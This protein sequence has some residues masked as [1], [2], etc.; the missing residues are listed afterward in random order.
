MKRGFLYLLIS[1]FTFFFANGQRDSK[2][3]HWGVNCSGELNY[4]G[5]YVAPSFTLDKNHSIS[6]GPLFNALPYYIMFPK[7]ENKYYP[8]NHQFYGGRIAYDHF[9]YTKRRYANIF[10]S[11]NLTFHHTV[12]SEYENSTTK[13]IISS[14]NKVEFL[15]LYLGLGNNFY[16]SPNFYFNYGINWGITIYENFDR[17]NNLAIP[18]RG[19]L[20]NTMVI[21]FGMGWM[22]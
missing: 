7:K 6:I 3:A 1:V 19:K 14:E 15:A 17:Q 20:S 2:N 22:L 11:S 10:I 18:D 16:V 13:N 5:I 12:F 4:F 9:V 21:R 8:K